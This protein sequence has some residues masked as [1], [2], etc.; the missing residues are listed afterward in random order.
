MRAATRV[1][2]IVAEPALP[3]VQAAGAAAERAASDKNLEQLHATLESVT[4]SRARLQQGMLEQLNAFRDKLALVEDE[5]R[6]LRLAL[7]LVG[8]GTATARA[9]AATQGKEEQ[10]ATLPP[11]PPPPQRP[12]Q[13]DAWD[14]RLSSI[15]STKVGSGGG[16]VRQAVL[17]AHPA[18]GK[19][20]AWGCPTCLRAQ[21]LEQAV[22]AASAAAAMARI[23][24][25]S[26]GRSP[27][28]KGAPRYVSAVAAGSLPR[29]L[30]GTPSSLLTRARLTSRALGC[31]DSGDDG[32]DTDDDLDQRAS[33]RRLERLRIAAAAGSGS[34][35]AGGTTS[36]P[37]SALKAAPGGRA[38]SRVPPDGSLLG[39]QAL[40]NVQAAL[41]QRA[42]G[43]PHP[44]DD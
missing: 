39:A 18:A 4:T 3:A 37:A 2:F 27:G 1:R 15:P 10:R 7:G 40:A 13:Q 17:V 38:S 14:E 35:V 32:D 22:S 9:I 12:P 25:A 33:R 36:R 44:W 26:A 42:G 20:S 43:R 19:E 24:A 30:A 23:S 41:R 5:N 6:Q 34:A 8:S 29:S 28:G 16:R 11:P 31:E 21:A